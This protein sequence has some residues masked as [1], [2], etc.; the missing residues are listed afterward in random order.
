VVVVADATTTYNQEVVRFD[1]DEDGVKKMMMDL[2]HVLKF[3][4]VVIPAFA[5]KIVCC[6]IAS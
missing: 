6:S 4:T 5:I 1:K 2:M 3:S